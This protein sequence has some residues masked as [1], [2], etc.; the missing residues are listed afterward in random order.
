MQVYAELSAQ[1]GDGRLPSGARINI[2]LLADQHEVS[3]P[4]IAHA[5]RILEAET[6]VTRYPRVGWVVN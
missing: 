5:L 3:R 4:T 1:I 6:K 2:G